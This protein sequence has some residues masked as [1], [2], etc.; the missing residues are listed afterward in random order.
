MK[1]PENIEEAVTILTETIQGAARTTTTP[2]PISRQ[3]KIIPQEIL[4]KIREKR[5]A[6]ANWQKHRT[7]ENKNT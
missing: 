7:R 2:E 6:K 3:T 4:E 5:K 1:T